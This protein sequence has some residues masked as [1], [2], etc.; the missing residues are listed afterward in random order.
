MQAHIRFRFQDG[1]HLIDH[2]QDGIGQVIGHIL[3]IRPHTGNR[4]K[5][6]ISS[7][8]ALVTTGADHTIIGSV[9]M[10]PKT[11]HEFF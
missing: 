11:L 4:K 1:R 9:S 2:F 6:P 7:G 3:A 5:L 8:D 10:H